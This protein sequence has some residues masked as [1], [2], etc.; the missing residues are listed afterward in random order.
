MRSNSAED[1]AQAFDALD[2]A[3]DRIVALRFDALTT[4][5]HF[6]GLERLE[7]ARRRM[8]VAE[9]QLINQISERATPAEVGGALPKV[10][11]N[12]LRITKGEASGRIKDA[13]L[14][15]DRTTLVGDGGRPARGRGRLRAR[16]RDL[17]LP[18]GITGLGG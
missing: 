6:R 4:P 14:L 15:G 8:P 5:E 13:Q 7:K 10:L 11:A 17:S 16:Q 9:H 12:K 2:A 18:E 3:L 1:A